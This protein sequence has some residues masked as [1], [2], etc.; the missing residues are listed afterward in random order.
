MKILDFLTVV[1]SLNFKFPFS[2]CTHISVSFSLSLFLSIPVSLSHSFSLCV[3]ISLTFSHSPSSSV[4]F[5]SFSFSLSHSH[6]LSLS[7]HS[8][9]L[10][11]SVSLSFSLRYWL[12]TSFCK[13]VGTFLC[14]EYLWGMKAWPLTLSIFL[15]ILSNFDSL[16]NDEI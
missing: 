8:P 5:L 6:S 13:R 9:S 16:R 2:L 14:P 12:Q 4:P 10:R 15:I 7:G 3:C 11:W 1:Y